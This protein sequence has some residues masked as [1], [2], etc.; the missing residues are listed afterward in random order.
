[1][2]KPDHGAAKSEGL[3]IAWDIAFPLATN[4]FFLYDMVKVTFISCFILL[5]ILTGILLSSRSAES[6]PT[7]LLIVGIMFAA[8][9]ALYFFI[10][11]V[12]FGNRYPT[13]F[14]VTERG[15]GWRSRSRR[16]N[17]ANTAAILLGLLAKKPGLA[18]AGMLAKA[19]EGGSMAWK[20]IRKVKAYAG[21]RS[22]TLMNSWRV[23]VRLYCLPD[24]YEDVLNEIQIRTGLT[25]RR[26]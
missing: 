22:I 24:N 5:L 16:G 17:T 12:F 6:L 13:T 21:P 11:L 8:F 19:G 15:V 1:M 7:I 25:A 20:D 2:N 23:V 3:P 18:G 4:R 26:G 10:A 14:A 9:N